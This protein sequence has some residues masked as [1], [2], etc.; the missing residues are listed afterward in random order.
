LQELLEL[1]LL[2]L[3]L[4]IAGNE[5]GRRS[6]P[7]DAREADEIQPA[8]I[9]KPDV[10]DHA[11]EPLRIRLELLEG[12]QGR[13]GRKAGVPGLTE[14]LAGHLTHDR[15]VIDHEKRGHR[16][17][18]C[19]LVQP[20][21]FLKGALEAAPMVDGRLTGRSTEVAPHSSSLRRRRPQERVCSYNGDEREVAVE[22]GRRQAP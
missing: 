12:G 1:R 8:H 7:M 16:A 3:G 15:F 19:W 5:E 14:G 20:T 21:A 9:R 11:V 6:R 13:I 18:W 10:Y 17:D 4:G 22:C 2:C